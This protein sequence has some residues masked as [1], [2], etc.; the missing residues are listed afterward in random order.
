MVRKAAER[1]AVNTPIQGTEADM[2][3]KAM[4]QVHELIEA[5]YKG[6][7]SMLLQVHDELLFEVEPALIKEVTPKIKKIM[8]NTITLSVP[9]IADA[10]HGL[11][12][13]TMKPV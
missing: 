7:I 3:K 2:I 9:I 13:E 12:W 1:M 10:K 4:I 8:E 6:K 11:D 5:E